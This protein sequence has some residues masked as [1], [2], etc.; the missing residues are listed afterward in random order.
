[1]GGGKAGEG[2]GAGWGAE[3]WEVEGLGGEVVEGRRG[4]L[5][6]IAMASGHCSSNRG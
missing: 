5:R 6:D 3:G 2:E 4:G 1:M